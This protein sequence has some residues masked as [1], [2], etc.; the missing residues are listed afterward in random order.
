MISLTDPIYGNHNISG[1]FEDLLNSKPVRRL[2]G[3]HHSGAIFLV[4]PSILHNRLE[5]S[6]GVM[7]L[8]KLLNGTELEQVAGLLHDLSHTVFSHVGDYVFNN[9][10]ED[11]HEKIFE[12]VLLSGDIP[13]ILKKYG[14]QVQDIIATKFD[15]LE[16]PLPSLCADRLDYTLR[17]ALHARLI[18]KDKA[19]AF[20]AHVTVQHGRIVIRDEAN[21]FWLNE[22]YNRLNVEVYNEPLYLFANQQMALLIRESLD[23]GLLSEAE[24]L[25]DDTFI[26]NK[27]RSTVRGFEAIKAIK[28][29]KGY[30]EF[31]RKGDMLKT[32]P[33]YLDAPVFS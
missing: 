33:R 21:A 26:L 9:T 18:S 11:Y 28:L 15:L 31:K 30:A 6:I 14:Y 7:L 4:N 17:D 1:L 8:L 22:L 3:I 27:I 16:Q 24:L 32:K 29:Q 12:S 19:K 25:K 5:H 13:L 20:L 2:A 10:N 23:S